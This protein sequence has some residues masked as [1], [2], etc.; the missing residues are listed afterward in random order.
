MAGFFGY[1]FYC[2][3]EAG[4]TTLTTTEFSR[5]SHL[6]RTDIFYSLKRYGE[7]KIAHCYVYMYASTTEPNPITLQVGRLEYIMLL[8]LSIILFSSSFY[9]SQ[10]YSQYKASYYITNLRILLY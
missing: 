9:Y 10:N 4:K 6:Y 1:C 5:M 7:V 8:K 3:V 2:A